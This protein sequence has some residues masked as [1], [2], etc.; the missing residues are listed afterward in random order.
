MRFLISNVLILLLTAKGS[1][2]KSIGVNIDK[3]V[4]GVT[5]GLTPLIPTL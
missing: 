2:M 3:I 4:E 5:I 1:V